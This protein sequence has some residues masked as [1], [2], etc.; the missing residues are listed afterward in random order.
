MNDIEKNVLTRING[1]LG[2]LKLKYA[3][4]DSDGN[5]HG[6]L[7][8]V[9]PRKRKA[10]YYGHGVMS[11]YIKPHFALFPDNTSKTIPAG[12]YDVEVVRGSVCNMATKMFGAGN[13]KTTL[14]ADRKGVVITRLNKDVAAFLKDSTTEELFSLDEIEAPQRETR[15]TR[16][17]R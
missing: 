3:I 4:V 16:L 8:V 1:A 13:Y 17:F 10:S 9:V 15:L 14:T 5:V 2:A 11:N 12:Q 6:D 7:E